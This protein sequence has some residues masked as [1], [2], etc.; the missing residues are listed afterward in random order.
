MA[1][2]TR[3]S[4]QAIVE[5]A[6]QALEDTC[7]NALT[8]VR[9]EQSVQLPD[10]FTLRFDDP[11]FELL[12]QMRFT[13]GTK[14]DVGFAAEGGPVVLTRGEVTALSIEQGPTGRHEMV[15][16]GM[17]ATHR[18][19]HQ[20][21]TRS[22]QQMTD[23]DIVDQVARD[24][25]LTTE[26]DATRQVHEYVLQSSVS[27]LAFLRARASLLG[28]DL[29]IADNKLYFKQV[30]TSSTSP[31]VLTW[32]RN[33]TKFKVRFSA[34]ERCDEV[35][36]RAWDPVA[37]RPIIGSAQTGD[38]GTTATLARDLGDAARQGFGSVTRFAGQVPVQTQAEA[39]ALAAS[40]LLKA[41]GEEVIARGEAVGDPRLTAG[42]TVKIEGMGPRLS[43]EYRVTSAEHIYATG[44]PYITRFV[45]GGKEPASLV[46]LLGGAA[47]GNGMRRG[48]GSLVV[49]VVTNSDDPEKLGRVRVKYPSLSESDESAWAR[50]VVPGGGKKRGMA[51][52]PEVGDE[53]LLG[54]ELDKKERP[55]VLGGLWNRDDAPPRDLVR[56]GSVDYKTW[57]TRDGHTIEIGD[58]DDPYITLSLAGG[59]CE[60]KIQKGSTV[61]KDPQG[62]KLESGTIEIKASTKLTLS[63]PSIEISADGNLV[64][65]GG[66]VQIN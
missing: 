13:P 58:V 7:R 29:W 24:Y 1:P 43:G 46:D 56:R 30:P 27:D 59:D 18:L 39:D 17:D 35:T 15:V 28:F 22:Y 64:L 31:P 34:A 37:K 25:G 32:R 10:A 6:G 16:S 9:V 61:L 19:A 11:D 49:G 33:L 20:P 5:V 41:S 36:V 12:D 45:C 65:K 40:L 23:A 44:S 4:E 47:G 54:F 8:S 2:S 57:A 3:H 53:V 55:V 66:V 52:L 42:A 38:T 62:A 21:K 48:W 63:A 51:L 60:L 26:V 50:V 14:V